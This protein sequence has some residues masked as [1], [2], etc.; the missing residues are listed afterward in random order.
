MKELPMERLAIT[1][2]SARRALRSK[3]HKNPLE[4]MVTSNGETV[5]YFLEMNFAG[6]IGAKTDASMVPFMQPWSRPP[7]E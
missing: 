2:L 7:T 4:G 3:E 5:G 6:D 1:A